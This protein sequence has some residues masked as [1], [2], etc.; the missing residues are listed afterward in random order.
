MGFPLL[1]D[2]WVTAK[3]QATLGELTTSCRLLRL[4]RMHPELPL[5]LVF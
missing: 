3:Q 1:D 4:P 5:G 2:L